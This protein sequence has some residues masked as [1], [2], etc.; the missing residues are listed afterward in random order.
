MVRALF[1]QSGA[2][3]GPVVC[4]CPVA[5]QSR[6]LTISLNWQEGVIDETLVNGLASDL[7]QWLRGLVRS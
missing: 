7:L 6:D 2:V 3:V 4:I 5:V 1:T